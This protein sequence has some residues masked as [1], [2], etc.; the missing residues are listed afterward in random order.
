MPSQSSKPNDYILR[1][2][3]MDFKELTTINNALDYFFNIIRFSWIF[4]NDGIEFQ[5]RAKCVITI[6]RKGGSSR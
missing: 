1:K 6:W 5:I 3:F 2:C 4:W